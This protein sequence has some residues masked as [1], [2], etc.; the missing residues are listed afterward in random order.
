MNGLSI[1]DIEV[2]DDYILRI[3]LESFT[4]KDKEEESKETIEYSG[5]AS[6][7]PETPDIIPTSPSSSSGVSSPGSSQS[8]K[9]LLVPVAPYAKIPDEFSKAYQFC[10]ANLKSLPF[11][12]NNLESIAQD[13]VIPD[14]FLFKYCNIKHYMPDEDDDSSSSSSQTNSSNSLKSATPVRT[15]TKTFLKI[16]FVIN[17]CDRGVWFKMQKQYRNQLKGF[18]PHKFGTFYPALLIVSTI[19]MCQFNTKIGPL[20]LWIYQSRYCA[21]ENIQV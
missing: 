3:E 6:E 16:Q 4:V 21:C 13:L 2:E 9:Y 8:S 10:E 1:S 18:K 7:N 14:R 11:N 17:A 12:L 15:M 19:T 20:P 5:L